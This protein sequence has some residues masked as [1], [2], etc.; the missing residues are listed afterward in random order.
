MLHP[1]P[2]NLVQFQLCK[3]VEFVELEI[4][5]FT[6]SW[7]WSSFKETHQV[8]VCVLTAWSYVQLVLGLW[9]GPN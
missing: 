6:N 3:L 1:T 4:P 9:R 7:N 8:T 5:S 2:L